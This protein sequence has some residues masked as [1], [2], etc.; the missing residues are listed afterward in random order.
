M[1]SKITNLII[2]IIIMN[3]FSCNT[4]ESI[5]KEKTITGIVQNILPGKDG[6]TAEVITPNEINYNAVISISNLGS[7]QNYQRLQPKDVATLTGK[8]YLVGEQ[9]TLIVN[10]IEEVEKANK[11]LMVKGRSF[12]GIAVGDKI[13]THKSKLG[14]DVLR[15]GEGEFT[16]YR[17]KDNRGQNVAYCLPDT[18]NEFLVGQI[19]I[20]SSEVKMENGISIGMAFHQLTDIYPDLKVHGSEI[21]GRTYANPNNELSFLLNVPNFQ[22]EVSRAAISDSAQVKEIWLK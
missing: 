16:V 11:K 15:N 4:E 12:M 21:E 19:V 13:M 3:A 10:Q 9:Q 20:H 14:K 17:L 6:Y 5:Q 7:S 8:Y 2:V 18:N 22:H 1:T